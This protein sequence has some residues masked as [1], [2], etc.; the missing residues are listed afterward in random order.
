VKLAL[1]AGTL[2]IEDG[3]ASTCTEYAK[4]LEE[5]SVKVGKMSECPEKSIVEE[6]K[7]DMERELERLLANIM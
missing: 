2:G 3:N 7:S 1:A 6:I 5:L 4:V